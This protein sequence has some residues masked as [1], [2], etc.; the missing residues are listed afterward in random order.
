MEQ[1]VSINPSASLA[2]MFDPAF[3]RAAIA[4]AEQWNLPR[5][6]CHPLDQYKGARV[7]ALTAAYDA[8][9]DGATLQDDDE[10]DEA[11]LHIDS[12]EE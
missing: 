12:D 6:I 8:E 2:A 3:A 11:S 1:T 7:N 10:M 4:R 9:I 5:N